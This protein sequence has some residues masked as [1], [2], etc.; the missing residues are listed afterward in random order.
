MEKRGAA[1]P[2][3]D[4]LAGVLRA[5]GP[6]RRDELYEM[7]EAWSR[8]AGPEVARRSR[9][10]GMN[11]DTLTVAVESASLRQEIES[12]RRP[13]ILARFRTEYPG[14]KVADLRC[15]LRGT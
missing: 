1:R 2:I 7:T 4:L 15:V 10:V 6:R 13:E 11:R 9:V 5:F 8:A 14:R 3:G 12:F